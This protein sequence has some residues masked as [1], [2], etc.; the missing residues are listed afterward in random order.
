VQ[1]DED[2]ELSKLATVDL[3]ALFG[4]KKVKSTSSLS[5]DLR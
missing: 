5:Y 3:G 2:E 4:E 1:V